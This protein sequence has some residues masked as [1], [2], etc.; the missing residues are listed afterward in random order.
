MIQNI[1]WLLIS[2]CGYNI[3]QV[4]DHLCRVWWSVFDSSTFNSYFCT[5]PASMSMWAPQGLKVGLLTV[6]MVASPMSAYM[7][8]KWDL[9]GF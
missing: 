6:S 3:I 5:D 1:T 9:T 7:G 4:T 8:L 2:L